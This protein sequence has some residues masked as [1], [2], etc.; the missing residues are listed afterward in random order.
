MNESVHV[1]KVSVSLSF[2]K[3]VCVGLYVSFKMSCVFELWLWLW[4][5]DMRGGVVVGDQG[6][7]GCRRSIPVS[8]GERWSVLEARRIDESVVIVG[9]GVGWLDGGVTRVETRVG[10]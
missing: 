5:P 9:D 8:G 2:K 6:E 7:G 3:R 10:N 4:C 1:S